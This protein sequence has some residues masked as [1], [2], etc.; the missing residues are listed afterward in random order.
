MRIDL[1]LNDWVE[2]APLPS[3]STYIMQGSLTAGFMFSQADVKPPHDS[4]GFIVR[5]DT[6]IED[7]LAGT[8]RLW[9]RAVEATQNNGYCVVEVR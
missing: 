8:A 9:V 5:G 7:R 4:V 1:P 3:M 2:V 6:I